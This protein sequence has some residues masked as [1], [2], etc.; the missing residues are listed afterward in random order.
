MFGCLIYPCTSTSNNLVASLHLL[1]CESVPLPPT[2]SS[3]FASNLVSPSDFFLEAD[4]TY[5]PSSGSFR[6]PSM[7]SKS[8]SWTSSPA[9][10]SI[11]F[12]CRQTPTHHRETPQSQEIITHGKGNALSNEHVKLFSSFLECRR[13]IIS[14]ANPTVVHHDC[15]NVSC[16]SAIVLDDLNGQCVCFFFFGC[17]D[18]HSSEPPMRKQ[19]RWICEHLRWNTRAKWL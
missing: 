1:A 12:S 7:L 17:D 11:H 19:I 16:K 13:G 9:R 4:P 5:Y 18:V 2:T 15:W 6:Q 10:L 14:K 3:H 8:G